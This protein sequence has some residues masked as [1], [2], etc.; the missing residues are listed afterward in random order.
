MVDPNPAAS[1]RRAPDHRPETEC[2]HQAAT[3]DRCGPCR[4]RFIQEPAD[5]D[6][7]EEYPSEQQP[8]QERGQKRL[9]LLRRIKSRL[10]A[11]RALRASSDWSA[12][13]PTP[14]VVSIAQ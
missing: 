9:F 3:P 7:E 5:D 13:K 6:E 10:T 8:R 1:H 2:H 4:R 14:R 11:I 12:D